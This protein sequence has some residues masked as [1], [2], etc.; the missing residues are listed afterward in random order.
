M[1]LGFAGGP[2]LTPAKTAKIRAAVPT[3][4][5]ASQ[6]APRQ[7]RF[8]VLVRRSPASTSKDADMVLESAPFRF[9][10]VLPVTAQ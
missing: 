4:A 3:F 1:L 2:P 6:T 5:S 7:T 8:A 10:R 9:A